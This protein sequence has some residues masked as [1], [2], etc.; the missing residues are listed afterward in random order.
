MKHIA[1]EYLLESGI[2]APEQMP[3]AESRLLNVLGDQDRVLVTMKSLDGRELK[4]PELTSRGVEQ[5]L[6]W[7]IAAVILVRMVFGAADLGKWSNSPAVRRMAPL[8]SAA[9]RI[10]PKRSR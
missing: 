2:V 3:G 5:F 4:V 7:L 9:V 6:R 8:R 10:F 1:K